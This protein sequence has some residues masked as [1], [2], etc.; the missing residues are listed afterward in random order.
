MKMKIERILKK[1]IKNIINNVEKNVGCIICQQ[2]LGKFTE[3]N[4]KKHQEICNFLK[5][6]EVTALLNIK[7]LLPR[8]KLEKPVMLYGTRLNF[9]RC[10]KL[11]FNKMNLLD[12]FY[13]NF[14]KYWFLPG[15]KE[16]L[17]KVFKL[18]FE[19]FTPV[20]L[21]HGSYTDRWREFFFSL[22]KTKKK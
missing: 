1:I 3:Q 9:E 11:H 4:K 16:Y 10:F 2:T 22:L 17:I 21:L 13:F 18:F 8:F 12:E 14:K 7:K 5:D 19:D 20:P 6:P 15:K